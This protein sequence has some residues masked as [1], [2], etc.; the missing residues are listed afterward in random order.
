MEVRVRVSEILLARVGVSGCCCEQ[1]K[2]N[3]HVF[4]V[5]VYEVKTM[6]GTNVDCLVPLC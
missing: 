1:V 5:Y 3:T 6:K 4:V 2:D